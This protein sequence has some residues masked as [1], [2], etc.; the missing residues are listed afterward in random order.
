MHDLFKI[1]NAFLQ[2]FTIQPRSKNSGAKICK[3]SLKKNVKSN[4]VNENQLWTFSDKL[5]VVSRLTLRGISNE[6]IYTVF[7]AA[8]IQTDFSNMQ[9]NRFGLFVLH[10]L[11]YIEYTLPKPEND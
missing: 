8:D 5:S 4:K 3:Y 10:R 1:H 9:H 2:Y 7:E 11:E 6:G